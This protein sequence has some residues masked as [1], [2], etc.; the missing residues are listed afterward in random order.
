M[1]SWD[2][3]K[4]AVTVGGW[5]SAV[6][7]ACGALALLFLVAA[8]SAAGRPAEQVG[9]LASSGSTASPGQTVAKYY[10]VGAP[11]NGRPDFLFAIAGRTPTPPARTLR[12]DRRHRGLPG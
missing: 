3:R 2:Y 12:L 7:S 9:P 8:P 5:R 1:A 6:G 11:V 10:V 4:A